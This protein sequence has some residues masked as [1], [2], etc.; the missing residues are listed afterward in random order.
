MSGINR[1]LV[2]AAR[3]GR[4]GAFEEIF[5]PLADSVYSL[6][7]GMV[8]AGY[9]D[10]LLQET[11]YRTLKSIGSLRE[12]AAFETWVYRIAVNAARNHI[13]KKKP[14]GGFSN[15]LWDSRPA[16][17]LPENTPSRDPAPPAA[18]SHRESL[19]LA[20]QTLAGLPDEEREVLVLRA[21]DGFSYKQIARYLGVSVAAV[22]MRLHRARRRA[23]ALLE[24]RER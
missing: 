15:S 19:M 17:G 4:P 23:S 9:A 16:A 8:G 5:L 10:D 1:E 11:V 7:V 18:V 21:L 3:Q 20:E 12:D 6:L 2:E 14:V 24:G 22:R 13:R